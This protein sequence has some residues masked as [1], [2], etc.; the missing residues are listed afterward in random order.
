MNVDSLSPP[1]NTPAEIADE[2]FSW[3]T[4]FGGSFDLVDLV[5][6]RAG[7]VIDYEAVEGS[8]YR[9]FDPNQGNYTLEAFI[10][11]R[12]RTSEIGAIFHHVSR[13]LSD[14]PK[15]EA[16]AWN[17][18]GV[19]VLHHFDTEHATVDLDVEGGRAVQHSFVDYTWLGQADALVRHQISPRVG[20]FGRARGQLF[21]VDDEVS[22]R[23]TQTGARVEGGVRLSGRGGVMELFLGYENRV[24]AYPFDRVPQHWG[25]AGLRLLSR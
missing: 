11:A 23:G 25:L 12:V 22:V 15:R 4:H 18:L 3:I 8:E 13:H 17:E 7:A 14:R 9:P 10:S 1:K 24:D 5:V 19:R 6:G 20:V 16:I 21:A 2:R